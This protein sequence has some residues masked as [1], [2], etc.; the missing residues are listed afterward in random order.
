MM[1]LLAPAAGCA[2]PPG[3]ATLNL[4]DLPKEPSM[5]PCSP[6]A[7]TTCGAKHGKLAAG[8]SQ[9]QTRCHEALLLQLSALLLGWGTACHG[10]SLGGT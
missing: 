9:N 5:M 6:R 7:V 10:G 4:P 1:L 8:P 3:K 2:T